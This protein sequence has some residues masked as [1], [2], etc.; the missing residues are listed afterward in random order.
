MTRRDF[1]LIAKV[2]NQVITGGALCM[3]NEDD[4]RD[5]VRQFADEL[6]AT[7]PNFD[8]Q[9]FATACGVEDIDKPRED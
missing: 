6:A 3:D 1:V 7:N 2:L 4:C 5:L 8:R 9:R